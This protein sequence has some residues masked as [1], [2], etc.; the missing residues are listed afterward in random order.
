MSQTNRETLCKHCDHFV[1]QNYLDDD[2]IE[3]VSSTVIDLID[4][5]GGKMRQ[6]RYIHL[7]DG[8]QEFDHDADPSGEIHTPEEWGK[9]RPDLFIK[10]PD[11]IGPNSKYHSQRGKITK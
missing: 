9:L 4:A 10:H 3:I 1:E 8:E 5:N 7:E 2:K 6:C 11:A